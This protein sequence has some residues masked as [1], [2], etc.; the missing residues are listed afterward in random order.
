MLTGRVLAAESSGC[1]WSVMKQNTMQEHIW[2]RRL[3]LN[4]RVIHDL[5]E[6]LLD[7]RGLG[8]CVRSLSSQWASLLLL[9]V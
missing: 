9:L 2:V 8:V 1:D 7:H 5:Q 6:H 4:V 3:G